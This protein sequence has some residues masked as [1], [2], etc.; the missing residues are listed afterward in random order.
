MAM[1]RT[2]RKNV[3][4]SAALV[5]I[6]AATTSRSSANG[7]I[8]ITSPSRRAMVAGTVSITTQV[9][10]SASLVKLYID[11]RLSQSSSASTF[12]WDSTRVHDGWHS[13]QVHTYGP[14][15]PGTQPSGVYATTGRLLGSPAVWVRVANTTTPT[16][17]PA[18]TPVPTDT[19]TPRATP[20]P[21]ATPAPASCSGGFGAGCESSL[22]SLNNPADPA[23][24]GAVG[25][26]QTDNTGAFQAAVN[27]GDVLVAPGTYLINGTVQVPN[28]RNIQCQSGAVLYTT[29][30]NSS[31]TAIL[32]WSG[33][34]YGSVANCTFAGSNSSVPAAFNPSQQANS[35]IELLAVRNVEIVGNIF[36]NTWSDAAVNVNYDSDPSAGSTNNIIEYN[37]FQ[38]NWLYGLA[39]VSGAYNTVQ[40]N[41]AIDCSMGAEAN[42]AGFQNTGNQFL[43]N[44]V[45]YVNGN[46]AGCGSECD[47]GI[48]LTCGETP[49]GFDYSGNYC[50]NN[51]VTGPYSGASW[52]NISRIRNDAPPGG[53]AASYSGDQC[54]SGC[55]CDVGGNC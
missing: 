26:G 1:E 2:S 54:V 36:E 24:Y 16:R 32:A 29:V 44:K 14:A 55:Q 34:G 11:H 48:E 35:L 40:Y 12:S 43:N 17:S 51:L 23:R 53:A 50:S 19:P 49:S 18:P 15:R 27:N 9:P 21:T 6:M 52:P 20:A 33:T 31:Q 28:G 41:L 37:T 39:I 45:Q 5:I 3:L 8:V 10:A 7:V 46:H 30:R 38:N 22:P 4:V 25:D 42:S 47:A 13:I